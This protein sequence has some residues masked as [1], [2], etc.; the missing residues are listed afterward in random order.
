MVTLDQIR[1]EIKSRLEIDKEIHSVSVRADSIEEALADAAVQLE[2]KTQNLEYEVEEKGS[3]G[4]LGIGKKPWLLKIYQSA[5]SIAKKM[6]E[7]DSEMFGENNFGENEVFVNKDGVY[8]VHKFASS[9]KLKV[10]LPVGNGRSVDL[11]DVLSSVKSQD[12]TDF[13]RELI[14]K[15]VKNGTNGDY[16][17]IGSYNHV[18]MADASVSVEVSKDEMHGLITVTPPGEGG[19]EATFDLIKRTLKAE[20][21]IHGINDEKI[22]EFIDNPIY[23]TP[24]EVASGTEPENGKDSYV[25]YKFETDVTKLQAQVSDDGNV[26]FKEQN[27][28]QNV[29]A[30]Q[31]LA[32]FVAATRGK[33][34]KTLYGHIL[35]CRDGR[36]S[37]IS[38]GKNVEF[39]KDKVTIIAQINGQVLLEHDRITVVPVLTL[40]AVNIK[41]GNITFLG[42]VIVKGNV[43]DGFSIDAKGG[44]DIGGTVGKSTILAEGDIVIHQGVFGKDEGYIKGKSLWGK[45]LQSTKIEVEENVIAT[46]SLMNCEVTAMKNIVLFGKKAQIT[47]GSYFATEEICARTVGSIG[48]AETVL[49]VGVDP[50]AKKELDSLQDQ[51]ADLMKEL[52]KIELD[53]STLE[54]QKKIRKTLSAEKEQNLAKFTERKD[55]ICSTSQKMNAR[56][57]ELQQHLRDL[58]SVGK[59]KV[60]GTIYAGAKIYVRDALDEVVTDVKNLTFY[61]EDGFIKRGKYESPSINPK[62]GPEGYTN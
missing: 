30:G 3:A 56:I 37:S 21:I 40:D 27:K 49:S 24:V 14:V 51:V 54:N 7:K 58:K 34:G 43:E 26:D 38:L 6:R 5:E 52:E 50:R 4:F 46:D 44:V 57:D 33:V 45:F 2:T 9:L 17:T 47:G 53:I 48:G 61:Y 11:K 36:N 28:I 41:T 32:V 23:G 29:I 10:I 15:Y 12:V 1:D 55:E 25:D 60:E 42:T 8:Y 35:E 62:K 39:A 31:T 13:D 20:G 59:V 22:I 16:E 18:A 19:S